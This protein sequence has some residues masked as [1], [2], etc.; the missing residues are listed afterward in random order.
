MLGA[1]MERASINSVASVPNPESAK[2]GA[3]QRRTLVLL[4]WVSAK[5]C[6]QNATPVDIRKAAFILI[7]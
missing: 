4:D 6:K 5:Y 7:V 1:T 2:N 3:Y